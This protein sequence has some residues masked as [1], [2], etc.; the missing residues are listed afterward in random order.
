MNYLGELIVLIGE[1]T[2]NE[3][4]FEVLNVPEK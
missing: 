3:Y 1:E 2:G 4:L